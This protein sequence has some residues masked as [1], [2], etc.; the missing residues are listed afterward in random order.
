VQL[1]S[2]GILGEYLGRIYDEVKQRPLYLTVEAPPKPG[3]NDGPQTADDDEGRMAIPHSGAGD[4]GRRQ[5]TSE[6]ARL[7]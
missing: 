6:A 7:P 2:L 3:S 5:A 1:I 4:E